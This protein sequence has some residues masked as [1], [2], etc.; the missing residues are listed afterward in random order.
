MF[1]SMKVKRLLGFTFSAS[2]S[3]VV[4][5]V[6]KS[7][8]LPVPTTVSQSR[9]GAK[10]PAF[11]VTVTLTEKARARLA[12]PKETIIV[13]VSLYGEPKQNT[14]LKVN[15]VGLVDLARQEIKLP[16]A[17][18]VR[19]DRLSFPTSTLNQLKSK[20]YS[21]NINVF[22]GRR[23]SPDNL[24]ECDIFDNKISKLRAGV[25]LKCGLIG[26][27]EGKTIDPS[28]SH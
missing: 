18:V 13:F 2:F 19:F 27:Y 23:S 14:S 16:K 1:S 15:E 6:S 9:D 20:D 28:N 7:N 3:L 11:D 8:A 21:A 5:S 4:A 26:E 12:S 24:L 25:T 22:S 10:A 17:G